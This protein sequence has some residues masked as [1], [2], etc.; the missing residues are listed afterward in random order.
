MRDGRD[1]GLGIGFKVGRYYIIHYIPRR[2]GRII[3]SFVLSWWERAMI[4]E[5]LNIYAYVLMI[6]DHRDCF[7]GCR[8][9]LVSF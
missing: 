8:R 3:G 6:L 2:E 5:R 7:G 1:W 9:V 4:N